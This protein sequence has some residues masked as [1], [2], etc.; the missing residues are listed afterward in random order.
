M[1]LGCFLENLK[2][3]LKQSVTPVISP[4][5]R[6]PLALQNPLKNAL[7]RLIDND[8]IAKVVD[9]TPEWVSNLVIVEKPNK[10]LR[11]CLDPKHI[12]EAVK[13]ETHMIPTLE[14]IAVKLSGKRIFSV[15]DIKDG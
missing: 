13:G 7:Q 14:E 2:I 15:L 3:E 5:R 1:K 8:I 9:E 10:D 4:A 12:N 11:L 6:V